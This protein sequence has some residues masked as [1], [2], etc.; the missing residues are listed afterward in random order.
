[1]KNEIAIKGTSSLACELIDKSEISLPKTDTM[2]VKA[3]S[4]TK[5]REFSDE[6]NTAEIMQNIKFIKKDLGVAPSKDD[7]YNTVRITSLIL[8][9]YSDLSSVEIALAFE[10][11]LIGELDDFLPK[12]RKGDSYEP[13]SEHYQNF[14]AKYVT[15]IL[16]AYKAKKLKTNSKVLLALPNSSEKV[17]TEEENIKARR[18]VWTQI[19]E[20]QERILSKDYV[21]NLSFNLVHFDEMQRLGLIPVSFGPIMM[22]AYLSAQ[23]KMLS[24]NYL[25]DQLK[26]RLKDDFR[27]GNFKSIQNRASIEQ[28]KI[29]AIE[30]LKITKR[31]E[32][33]KIMKQS[34]KAKYN[35]RY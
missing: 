21:S 14:S 6:K 24:R 23:S 34:E 11:L 29:Q 35:H 28:T 31:S 3:S 30:S 26:A 25:P 9:H 10:L 32:I 22:K 27:N 1:M 18:V 20:A 5:M 13:D 7:E 17:F 15:K 19:L 33:I 16:K 4:K 2:I 8:N 12:R